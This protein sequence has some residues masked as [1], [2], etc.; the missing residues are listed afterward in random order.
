MGCKFN[1]S[2]CI[3]NHLDC[4][5]WMFCQH[6]LSECLFCVI[7]RFIRRQ[8]SISMQWNRIIGL[9]IS[10]QSETSLIEIEFKHEIIIDLFIIILNNI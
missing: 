5:V 1:V 7:P 8:F 9:K 10:Q 4:F 3:L 6:K 2:D